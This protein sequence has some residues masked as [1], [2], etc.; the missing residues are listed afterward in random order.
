MTPARTWSS[1]NGSIILWSRAM[2]VIHVSGL[3]LIV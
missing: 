2:R 1:T 3:M